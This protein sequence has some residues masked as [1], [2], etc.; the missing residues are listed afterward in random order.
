MKTFSIEVEY[1]VTEQITVRAENIDDA[2]EK[3]LDMV[4]QNATDKNIVGDTQEDA[5]IVSSCEIED[6]DS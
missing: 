1:T 2:E 4:A 6:E 5:E 3:A